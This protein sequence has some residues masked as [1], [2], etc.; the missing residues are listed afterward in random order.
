ML[1]EPIAKFAFRIAF[2]AVING[3]SK[4]KKP[5]IKLNQSK[6]AAIL[7]KMVTRR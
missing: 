1:S 3:P 4:P 7:N 6:T 2:V 5:R